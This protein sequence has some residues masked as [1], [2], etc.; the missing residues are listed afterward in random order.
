M[1]TAEQYRRYA[2]ECVR[3]AQKNKDREEKDMLLQMAQGWRVLAQRAE[4]LE[5][6]ERKR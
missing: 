3:L 5:Q 6:E 4:R 2:A 1:P